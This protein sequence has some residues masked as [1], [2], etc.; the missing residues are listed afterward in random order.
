MREISSRGRGGQRTVVAS[1]ILV[2]ALAI[3][4]KYG[5][6]IPYFGFERGGI[7][8][9]IPCSLFPVYIP[10][11]HSVLRVKML[12]WERVGRSD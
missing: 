12:P 10:T 6:A 2:N 9:P 11:P 8:F 3:E 1:Q 4:G 7:H 5:A